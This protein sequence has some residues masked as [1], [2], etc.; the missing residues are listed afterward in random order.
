M[1]QYSSDDENYR[2]CAS[3]PGSTGPQKQANDKD[4]RPHT[5]ELL[6]KRMRLF[7]QQ[8]HLVDLAEIET[9]PIF[10]EEVR[11]R[12]TNLASSPPRSVYSQYGVIAAKADSGGPQSPEG[13]LYYNVAAPSSTFICGSQGSGKSHTLSC[14]LENCL[15]PSDANELPRPL[16]GVVFHYDT[17]VCDAAGSPCE[18]AFL[19]CHSAVEVRVL[20]APTNV[21]FIRET[22]SRF[23]RVKVEELRFKE[24]DLNTKRMMDMMAV[25]EGAK[26]PLYLHVV[27]RILRDLRLEQQRTGSAF[28][29]AA[30]GQ[31]IEQEQLT[32]G[33]KGPLLQR[34][35][36]L[37][38]FLAKKQAEAFVPPSDGGK[39]NNIEVAGSDWTP[40]P[41]QLTIVDL[42]CPCVTAETACSLFNVCLSLFLQQSSAVGR[43]VALDEAHKYMNDSGEAGTLTEQLIATIR[44]QRHL[45]ARVII[46]TQEPTVSPRLLDLC[47]VT[48]VH[49]FTSPDWLAA[50]KKHLVGASAASR[51]MEEAGE[52]GDRQDAAEEL[53]ARVV[54]LRVGEALL[55]APS[56]VLGLE[57]GLR[58]QKLN[59]S[60]LKIQVRKRI[61]D[62]GGKSIMAN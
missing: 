7:D 59:H 10:T 6:L 23:P 52:D 13:L 50:L 24:T 31:M 26:M 11:Q 61:T 3:Y 12:A 43:V 8:Q 45:G 22:Y 15:A 54:R 60:V 9:A 33:Q 62:D 34:L 1:H 4:N 56:A 40:K 46:S 39:N 28:D 44:L 21:A 27:S 2:S 16:T 20:C 51:I 38:S 55:F 48:I 36:T 30:F 17:F 49:R 53:F 18:A 37:Q 58:A 14:L 35:D 29:Y 41:A 57:E 47:S 5:P 25:K 42:S 32:P 19:S